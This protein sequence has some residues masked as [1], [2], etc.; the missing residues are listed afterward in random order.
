LLDSPYSIL[1]VICKEI[2]K[3]KDVLDKPIDFLYNVTGY[4]F[5]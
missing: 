1:N 4:I 2:T 5:F 3:I